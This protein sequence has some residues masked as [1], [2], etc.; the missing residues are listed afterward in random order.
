[1]PRLS[2][3]RSIYRSAKATIC[4]SLNHDIRVIASDWNAIR[5]IASIYDLLVVVCIGCR[6]VALL[7]RSAVEPSSQPGSQ[8]PLLYVATWQGRPAPTSGPAQ[9]GRQA[10]SQASSPL[11]LRLRRWRSSTGGRGRSH[12]PDP[13]RPVEPPITS[14]TGAQAHGRARLL[15]PGGPYT[16]RFSRW[17][18]SPGLQTVLGHPSGLGAPT[19]YQHFQTLVRRANPSEPLA[20]QLRARLPGV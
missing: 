20:R 5:S 6:L 17:T 2:N 18:C 4:R 9:P 15:G 8:A 11:L 7:C 1:M 14:H 16:P 13:N 12:A 10:S 19:A 3:G